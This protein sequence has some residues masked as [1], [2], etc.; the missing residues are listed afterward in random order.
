MHPRLPGFEGI[1]LL[2]FC[3]CLPYVY[4]IMD[5]FTIQWLDCV[6]V[7]RFPRR[8]KGEPCAPAYLEVRAHDR[9]G[10]SHGDRHSSAHLN[11][12]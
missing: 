2:W 7:F 6:F 9:T 11:T 1:L 4:F 8:I 12:I 10:I 3:C 5:A